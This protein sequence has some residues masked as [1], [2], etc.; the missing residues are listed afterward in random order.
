MAV[1]LNRPARE[2]SIASQKDKLMSSMISYNFDDLMRY[3]FN[4]L[5]INKLWRIKI[6]SAAHQVQNHDAEF[7]AF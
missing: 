6:A 4:I 7:D 5:I 2:G 1:S 3:R